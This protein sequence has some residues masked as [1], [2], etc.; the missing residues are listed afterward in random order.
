MDLGSSAPWDAEFEIWFKNGIDRGW[1]S[2]P[3]C[4]THE[5]PPMSEEEAKQWEEGGDPCTFHVR[6]WEIE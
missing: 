2:Q 1:I 4:D 5:G 6:V 3:F